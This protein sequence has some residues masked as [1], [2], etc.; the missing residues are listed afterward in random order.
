MDFIFLHNKGRISFQLSGVLPLGKDG[1][2]K[3]FKDKLS[4][5]QI[6]EVLKHFPK[7]VRKGK[8]EEEG[9]E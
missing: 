3:Q 8:E 2:K 1:F 9:G 4:E 7:E 5:D 6:K